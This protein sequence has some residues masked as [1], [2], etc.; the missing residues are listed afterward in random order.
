M[1]DCVEWDGVGAGGSRCGATLSASSAED[2]PDSLLVAGVCRLTEARNFRCA[3]RLIFE[4]AAAAM[5]A[6]SNLQLCA[7]ALGPR[8]MGSMQR[9]QQ[10]RLSAMQP[11]RLSRRPLLPIAGAGK[12]FGKV[13]QQPKKRTDEE[14]CAAE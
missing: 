7:S 4:S 8:T 11:G 9:M 3:L 13:S 10:C 14:V 2:E 5:T 6:V 1:W 12:G